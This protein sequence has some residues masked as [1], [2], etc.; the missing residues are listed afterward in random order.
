MYLV[1]Y[2]EYFIVLSYNFDAILLTNN[3]RFFMAKLT[4]CKWDCSLFLVSVVS[5][6]LVLKELLTLLKWFHISLAHALRQLSISP[7]RRSEAALSLWER[8]MFSCVNLAHESGIVILKLK[9]TENDCLAFLLNIEHIFSLKSKKSSNHYR[10]N[11]YLFF[12][13]SYVSVHPSR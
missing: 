6:I 8:A 2:I 11:W 5:R 7:R 12:L 9:S 3:E 1:C 13:F 4:L 10:R